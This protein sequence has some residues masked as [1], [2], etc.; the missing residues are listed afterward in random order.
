LRNINAIHQ[1]HLAS[2]RE[3]YDYKLETLQ[4]NA[5]EGKQNLYQ[6][7]YET[8][9]ALEERHEIIDEHKAQYESQIQAQKL[10]IGRLKYEIDD[11]VARRE[12][13]EKEISKIIDNNDAIEGNLRIIFGMNL[14]KIV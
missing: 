8:D 14:N 12:K 5:H 11:L 2:L 1:S 13:T 6:L 9:K 4:Q 3:D 10:E 7:I